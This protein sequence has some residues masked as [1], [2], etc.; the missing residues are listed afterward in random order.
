MFPYRVLLSSLLLLAAAAT[1]SRAAEVVPPPQ[2]ELYRVITLRAAP[3]KLSDLLALFADAGAAG[4]WQATGDPEPM[5]MRHS[6]G[7]H[8]DLLLLQP[9]GS[10]REYFS[11]SRSRRRERAGAVVM[12]EAVSQLVNFREDFFAWGPPASEVR[13]AY[14]AAG[15]FHIEMFSAL[16][17]QH[18][19]LRVQ[20]EMENRYL[21]AIR[22]PSNLIWV[23]DFGSDVDVFT[24]GFHASLAAFAAPPAVSEEQE[25]AAAKAAGFVGRQFIGTYL[26]ELITSHHDTLAVKP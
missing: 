11:A 24:I 9:I 22:Q 10:Y 17:G 15:L 21:R 3:G 26:R 6:Q 14:A 7:D 19:A 1:E 12:R 4:H 8:W 2:S 13:A 16:A 23:V 25:D 5:L 18:E 20:R